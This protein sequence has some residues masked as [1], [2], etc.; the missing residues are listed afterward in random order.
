MPRFFHLDGRVSTVASLFSS[1]HLL[2]MMDFCNDWG[3]CLGQPGL[4]I[5]SVLQPV[6]S[7]AVWLADCMHLAMTCAPKKVLNQIHVLPGRGW[8]CSWGHSS[9]GKSPRTFLEE[10]VLFYITHLIFPPLANLQR[11]KNNQYL[12]EPGGLKNPFLHK[13]G[14]TRAGGRGLAH[15]VNIIRLLPP[16]ALS[17][18]FKLDPCCSEF[19]HFSL[20]TL[21]KW[22]SHRV[23]KSSL[24]WGAG[25]DLWHSRGLWKWKDVSAEAQVKQKSKNV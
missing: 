19:C 22:T 1:S 15:E 10:L 17:W 20:V 3:R 23:L 2:V 25:S 7:Q 5:S 4:S 14:K 16:K 12:T 8:H 18:N 13:L 6:V 9:R 21:T 24:W 11:S